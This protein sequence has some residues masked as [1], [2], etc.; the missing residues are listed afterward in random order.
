MTTYCVFRLHA[1][2]ASWGE[3]ATGED[4]HSSDHPSKSAVVGLIAAALGITRDQEAIHTQLTQ[5]IGFAC[6]VHHAGVP[7]EDFHTIQTPPQSELNKGSHFHTRKDELSIG[8]DRLYTIISR[9]EYRCDPWIS[10][11][12][13]ERS[14]GAPFHL[15]DIA[16]A[17]NNPVFFLYLGR[18]SCPPAY[19][20]HAVILEAPSILEA[21]R[22]DGW[23]PSEVVEGM[24]LPEEVA[25]YWDV[26]GTA[27]VSPRHIYQRRDE[28]LSRKRW[29]FSNRSEHFEMVTMPGQ[30]VL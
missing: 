4:R 10:V 15:H 5:T 9:R 23:K 6:L 17:L 21:F 8:S 16:A 13:W 30:E 11:C 28:V 19:P 22:S 26:D 7:V 25:M 2:M 27:G 29:A 14:E 3:I 12:L 1:P 18:K 24:M 20:L